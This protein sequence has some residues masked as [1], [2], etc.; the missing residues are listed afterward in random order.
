MSQ[1]LQVGTQT[2]SAE[3]VVTLLANYQMLPQFLREIMIDQAIAPFAC[4]SEEQAEACQKFYQKYQI[5]TEVER[6]EWL[7]LYEM[8]L[9]DLEVLACRE[10]RIEKFKRA[11]WQHKLKSYFLDHKSSLDQ[12]IYSQIRVKDAGVANELYFRI[13]EGEQTLAELA[14]KYAPEP[15]AKTGGLIGPIEL[16]QLNPALVPKFYAHLPGQLLPLT[17]FGEWFAIIRLEQL[18]PAQLNE[19]MQQN[20]LDEQFEAWIEEQLAQFVNE[21]LISIN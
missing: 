18:I 17:Q 14:Q 16:G 7:E 3:K 4:T 13:Q 9:E 19:A 10:Q 6:Q 5:T 12:V 11:T 2:I 21:G 1:A 8:T 15:E 20:L